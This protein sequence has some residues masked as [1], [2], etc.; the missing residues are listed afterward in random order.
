MADSPQ[1]TL[2]PT[3]RE[4]QP[5]GW[6]QTIVA[7]PALV[8]RSGGQ[9]QG[10]VLELRPGTQ[11]IGR[12]PGCELRIDD[13]FVSRRHAI[14]A[15][16]RDASWLEDAGSANGT[17]LN[18][19]QLLSRQRRPLR[20]GDVV[21]IGRIDLVYLDGSETP[22]R[23]QALLQPPEA[24][25]PVEVLSRSPTD[26]TP[27]LLP[28]ATLPP[29]PKPTA[30]T[31]PLTPMQLALSAAAASLTALLLSRRDVGQLGTTVGAGLTTVVTTFLQTR[32]R[33]QW[34][35]IATGAG[36]ALALAVTGVT[37]P[38]LAFGSKNRPLTFVPPKLD[39]R[40]TVPA[41]SVDP[42]PA[43]SVDPNPVDCGA[44]PI[45]QEAACSTEIR[46][47]G[48][49]PGGNAPQPGQ[50]P[51]T[52]STSSPNTGPVR[53]GKVTTA[54]RDS[55]TSISDD[56]RALTTAFSDFE[57][58]VDPTSAESEATKTFTMT[59]PLTD[60]AEGETLWVYAQGY[61]FFDGGAKGSVTLRGG[62][63]QIIQGYATP[64]DES[65]VQTLELP[66]R[67]GVTYKLTFAIDIDQSAD[68]EGTGYLNIAAIDI[69]I[70]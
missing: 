19:E 43:I 8:I 56:R 9:L 24:G 48:S 51:A 59:M 2:A 49:G 31:S 33:K 10:R 1:R 40:T 66:A 64:T 39:P 22:T 61:A 54:G 25:P 18:G 63:Q 28:P 32:G 26:D 7:Q 69:G 35:R 58:A 47:I 3:G 46:T 44:A 13:G 11:V 52:P 53:F 57:V 5:T 30:D 65:F 68:N 15:H 42:S 27:P 50:E 14:L 21:R 37:L 4:Q 29:T 17:S 55:D 16:D 45:G 34:L 70:R 12:Q 36:L 20:S 62:G 60:G 41:T 23:R 38:E 67:P 6:D